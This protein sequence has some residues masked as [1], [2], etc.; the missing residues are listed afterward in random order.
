MITNYNALI[1]VSLMTA[2]MLLMSVIGFGMV[3]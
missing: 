2:V 3:S 1:Y